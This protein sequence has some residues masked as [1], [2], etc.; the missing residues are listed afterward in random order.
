MAQIDTKK[1]IIQFLNLCVEYT[2]SSLQR[3]SKRLID[4]NEEELKLAKIEIE[5]WEIY[6][7]FTEYTI[8]ELSSG[9]LDEWIDNLHNPKYI[10]KPQNTH[11]TIER[12]NNFKFTTPLESFISNS[13]PVL[14]SRQRSSDNALTS[15][16][17]QQFVKTRPAGTR[18]PHLW[19]RTA[20]VSHWFSWAIRRTLKIGKTVLNCAAA[21]GQLEPIWGT[22]HDRT[23]D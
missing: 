21:R 2:N 23:A 18:L 11:W 19:S 8:K 4:L 20:S 5:K 14:I 15:R 22:S 12:F 13:S 9:D 16:P 17:G 10:P 3:K 7:Q 1:D 6:K